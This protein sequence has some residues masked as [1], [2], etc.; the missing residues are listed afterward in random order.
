MPVVYSH[1]MHTNTGRAKDSLRELVMPM[2]EWC[3][4]YLGDSPSATSPP[5]RLDPNGETYQACIPAVTDIEDVIQSH[6]YGIKGQIDASV[7]SYLLQMLFLNTC[8]A[9]VMLAR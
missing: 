2:Q 6:K 9:Y 3:A 5:L 8:L 4:A 7:V 1:I